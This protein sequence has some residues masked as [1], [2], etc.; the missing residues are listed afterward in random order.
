MNFNGDNNRPDQD[1]NRKK[2]NRTNLIICVAAALFALC[3]IL[4]LNNEIQ[5]NTQ[6]EITYTKFIAMLKE[7]QVEKVTFKS[8]LI[9]IEPKMDSS[10][11]ALFKVSYYTGY[12]NDTSLVENL[13]NEYGVKFTAE[14]CDT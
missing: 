10:N 13:L 11:G 5:S 6:K 14:I 1:P 3:M 7:G 2:R 12:V 4:F 9:Y 8:N